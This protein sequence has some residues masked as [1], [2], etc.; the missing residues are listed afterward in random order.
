M[1]AEAAVHQARQHAHVGLPFVL[2][3]QFAGELGG[4]VWC[5]EP[6]QLTA[7]RA[8]RAVG[9]LARRVGKALGLGAHVEQHLLG[10]TAQRGHVHALGDGEQDVPGLHALAHGVVGGVRGEVPAAGGLVGLGHA[11]VLVEPAV[12]GIECRLGVHAVL[13]RGVG[14]VE[15]A[16]LDGVLA[17]QLQA[18][19]LAAL[20]VAQR[21]GVFRQGDVTHAQHDGRDVD[22]GGVQHGETP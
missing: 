16:V 13:R 8:A 10:A 22:G 20:G 7:L 5:F 15:Q 3:E 6:T 17:Q 18:G 1:Q 21:V 11:D 9:P 14:S 19:A 2:P 12:D 4:A